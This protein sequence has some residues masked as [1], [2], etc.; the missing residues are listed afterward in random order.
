MCQGNRQRAAQTLGIGRTSLY[1]YLKRDGQ[2]GEEP[3]KSGWCDRLAP[4]SQQCR[5]VEHCRFFR[6]VW[7]VCWAA[8]LHFAGSLGPLV[9]RF[10]FD[11]HLPLCVNSRVKNARPENCSAEGQFS[12]VDAEDPCP[13]LPNDTKRELCCLRLW[14]DQ[15]NQEQRSIDRF[16]IA[17]Q[18]M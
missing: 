12:Q 2:E 11:R 4:R 15:C 16:G 1:R 17:R 5:H 18:P 3:E 10:R 9:R 7:P 13:L 8:S 6:F 14:H